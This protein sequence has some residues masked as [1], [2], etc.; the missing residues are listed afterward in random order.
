MFEVRN[1]D[2]GE[3]QCNCP[4]LNKGVEIALALRDDTSNPRRP[5][6]VVL[7]GDEIKYDTRNGHTD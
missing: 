2:T 1:Y 4:S 7:Y 5:R 6:M 3:I